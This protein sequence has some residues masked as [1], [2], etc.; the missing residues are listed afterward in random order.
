MR[1]AVAKGT[2]REDLFYR[3][4]VFP[5][6]WL[7]LRERPQ[8]IVPIAEHLIQKHAAQLNRSAASL[9]ECARTELLSRAWPGNIRE[10]DNVVQRALILQPG[11][12]LQAADLWSD[13]DIYG[14][15][16]ELEAANDPAPEAAPEPAR[17]A[18]ASAALGDNMAQHE[19]DL[20]LETLRA[21]DGNRKRSAEKLGI[22]AR[23]LRYKLARMREQ[24][25]DVEAQ[26]MPQPA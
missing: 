21:F 13:D 25:I 15:L 4:N 26:L 8:D 11:A 18:S 16:P 19:F 23:T 22:S 7:P 12:E 17:A 2:F 6:R 20:I 14:E 24:G 5:L 10:L 9:S 1:E 3:L